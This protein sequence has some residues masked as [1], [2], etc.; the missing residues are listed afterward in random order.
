MVE[1]E[2]PAKVNFDLKVATPDS[3]GMH[4]LRSI[5]QTIDWCDRLEV[6][7]GH[8]D[9]LE[10]MGADIDV[11]RSNLVWRAVDALNLESR[12][13]LSVSLE[14][15][16]PA[17][18]GLGGGSSDA[19]AM[20]MCLA[21]IVSL[22]EGVVREV[23]FGIGADV[24]VFI[25]GGTLLVEG[26]G[27]RISPLEPLEGFVIGVAVPP[28]ELPTPRVFERWDILGNPV[29]AEWASRDLPP[30]MRSFEAMRNDLT[31]AAVDVRPEL[32]DWMGEL[33]ERWERRVAMSGS[34]PS[35]F[36]YFADLDEAQGAVASA[37]ET[38]AAA[39]VPLRP[40]GAARV[41]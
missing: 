41:N 39:A 29:G 38:R 10:V 12:P 6:E 27:E 40:L 30:P 31:P 33:S 17:A 9:Y 20:L 1:W 18:A 14:K 21:E 2:A 36:A 26:Y 15:R 35:C 32:A 28:F 23:A 34:G 37:P 8:E 24:P 3:E 13:Q 11:D 16:I 7:A 5:T 4:P 25:D 19:A 22:D